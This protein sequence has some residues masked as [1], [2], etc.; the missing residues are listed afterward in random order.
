MSQAIKVGCHADLRQCEAHRS[1][2][3]DRSER[4]DAYLLFAALAMRCRGEDVWA[5]SRDAREIRVE[6][7]RY[8]RISD[9]SSPSAPTYVLAT[10][11]ARSGAFAARSDPYA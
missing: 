3:R 9:L 5:P 2:D 8:P 1:G 7:T 11:S 6:C 4:A 10:E